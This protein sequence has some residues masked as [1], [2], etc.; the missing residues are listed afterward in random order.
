MFLIFNNFNNLY[1]LELIIKKIGTQTVKIK[2]GVN[3]ASSASVVGQREGNGPLKEYFDLIV[4][5]TETEK[6]WEKIESI[7]LK[8]AVEK[9]LL[10]TNINLNEIDYILGGDLLNQCMSSNFG[11]K[12]FKIP[13]FGL[14]GA[15]STLAEGM[16]IGSMLI[17]GDFGENLLTVTSSHFCTAERQY[18]TPLEYGAQRPPMS[19]WTVTASG[20]VMLSKKE[21]GPKI[22]HLTVGKI[23]DL[24][25][26]DPNNMG[27]SMA[28]AAYDTLKAHFEDTNRTPEFY[29]LILTGDLGKYGSNILI[30]LFKTSNIEL[31]NYNDAG[32]LIFNDDDDTKGS[33]SGSGCLAAVFSGFIIKKLKEKK[34]KNILV[35]GTGALMSLT[36]FLQGENIP[37][38]AHAVAINCDF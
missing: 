36:S 5:D 3:I 16:I 10:K 28:P 37:A 4:K 14:Y 11:L 22:T 6:S 1:N 17:D 31:K 30:D 12:E 32:C 7:M 23:I 15:C 35:V 26:K 38:I 2:N 20:C 18:R 25:I 8:H 29:D 27:A 13:F 34:F 19:Q 21:N 33:A 24:G 9:T